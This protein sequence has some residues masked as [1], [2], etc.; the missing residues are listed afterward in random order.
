LALVLSPLS[1]H[2]Q[3][4]KGDPAVDEFGLDSHF[5]ELG[6][7]ASMKATLG[8]AVR[9]GSVSIWGDEDGAVKW[10]Q[11]VGW[12]GGIPQRPIHQIPQRP[13]HQIPQRPIHHILMYMCAVGDAPS[14]MCYNSACHHSASHTLPAQVLRESGAPAPLNF[15]V[16]VRLNGNF[17][18]LFSYMEMLGKNFLKVREKQTDFLGLSRES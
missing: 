9:S 17:L 12:G 8:L 16:H 7:R 2:T 13:I 14:E 6:E 11:G 18:G 4:V 15:H 3:V 1:T 5:F 10:A